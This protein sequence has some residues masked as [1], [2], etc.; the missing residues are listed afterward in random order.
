M[1]TTPITGVSFKPLLWETK[2]ESIH[3]V[4][5]LL[6]SATAGHINSCKTAG[7]LPEPFGS[8]AGSTRSETQCPSGYLLSFPVRGKRMSVGRRVHSAHSYLHN[9]TGISL[10]TKN[11]GFNRQLPSEFPAVLSLQQAVAKGSIGSCKASLYVPG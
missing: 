1:F 9:R 8:D 6:L 4:L 10:S 3:I 5:S 11:Y 2:D 7:E